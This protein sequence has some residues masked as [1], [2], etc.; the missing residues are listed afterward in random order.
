MHGLFIL[1]IGSDNILT[2]RIF[3]R[4]PPGGIKFVQMPGEKKEFRKA[5]GFTELPF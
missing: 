4:K 1:S 2:A 5:G 3:R